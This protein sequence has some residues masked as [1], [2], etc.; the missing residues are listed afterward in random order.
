VN[1]IE[2]NYTD[3]SN[4]N[5]NISIAHSSYIAPEITIGKIYY[6]KKKKKIHIFLNINKIKKIYIYYI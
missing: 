4:N 5:N 1:I 2:H 6:Y 3:N